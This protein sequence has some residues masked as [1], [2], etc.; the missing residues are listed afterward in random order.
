MGRRVNLRREFRKGDHVTVHRVDDGVSRM[1]LFVRQT[2]RYVVL[3]AY[4]IEV[5]GNLHRMKGDELLIPR[6]RIDLLERS[7]P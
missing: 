6:D 2:R 5:D 1:G 4:S 7:R 3:S